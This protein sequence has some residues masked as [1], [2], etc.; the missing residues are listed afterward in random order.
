VTGLSKNL[1][2]VGYGSL[3]L[4][5]MLKCLPQSN[6]KKLNV[7]SSGHMGQYRNIDSSYQHMQDYTYHF[8]SSELPWTTGWVLLQSLTLLLIVLM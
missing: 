2:I 1:N 4:Q 8:L 6:E 5:V 3:A 7:K